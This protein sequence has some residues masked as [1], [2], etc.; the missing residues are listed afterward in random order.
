[1]LNQDLAQRFF[2]RVKEQAAGLM[3]D[4]HFTVDGTLVEAWVGQSPKES[5]RLPVQLR[6]LHWIHL[7]AAAFFAALTF[8]HLARCAAAIFL[9]ADA[10]MVRFAG[11][12]PATAFA[13]CDPFRAFAH[14]FF[15]AMLMRLRAEAERVRPGLV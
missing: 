15:C 14:R 2:A 3:S 10:E 11:A 7:Q 5:L 4:E 12:E 8:A 6:L 9:R 1:L 13:G